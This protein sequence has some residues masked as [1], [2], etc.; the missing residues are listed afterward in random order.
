MNDGI[1]EKNGNKNV[2]GHNIAT[3]WSSQDAII[4][5]KLCMNFELKLC[6]HKKKQKQ[7]FIVN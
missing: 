2:E 5:D 6:R 3:Q 1:Q 4:R 7:V